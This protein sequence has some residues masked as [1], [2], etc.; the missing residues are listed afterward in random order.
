M[1]PK[2]VDSQQGIP[3]KAGLEELHTEP[4]GEHIWTPY[5]TVPP[6]PPGPCSLKR[7]V[8]F[9]NVHLASNSLP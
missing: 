6:K 8:L 9:W 2:P 3:A 7:A 5:P 4:G 1:R